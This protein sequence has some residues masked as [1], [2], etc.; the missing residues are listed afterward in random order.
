MR[1]GRYA[2]GLFDERS[3][4]ASGGQRSKKIND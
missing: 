4:A 3:T 2:R 1:I